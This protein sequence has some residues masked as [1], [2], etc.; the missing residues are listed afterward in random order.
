MFVQQTGGSGL[1]QG[2]QVTGSAPAPGSTTDAS[3]DA[4]YD[5]LGSS[6]ASMP[7]LDIVSS[8]V[9]RPLAATCHPAGTACLR[10]TIKVAN[11]STAAALTPDTD[12]DLVWQTQW[13]V[14]ASASCD[15]SLASCASGGL[16]FDVYAE[17]TGSGSVQCWAGQN[18]L[19]QNAEGVQLTYPGT[20]QLTAPGA[21]SVVGGPN[22]TITIDVP[23]T[24]VS[25]DPGV[26]PYSSTLYSVTA[27]TMTLPAQANSVPWTGGVGG[28]AF[29]LIDVA[30]A[31]DAQP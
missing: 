8:S 9:T 2:K 20:T 15:P 25:L 6:S 29:N 27:S 19:E 24:L 21:C 31:Y 23:V 4:T 17:W 11:M 26:A 14:P 7:N 28:I 18:A 16:N 3:G 10:V 30:P 13:L 5:A 1:Y 12:S 22:G